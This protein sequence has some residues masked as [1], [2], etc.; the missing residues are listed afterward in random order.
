MVDRSLAEKFERVLNTIKAYPKQFE[1]AWDEVSALELPENY[2]SV[3]NIVF[4]GMG[5]SA[6]GARM[7][8]AFT[9]EGRLRVP[10]EIF[11]EYNIPNYAGP[12]TL[13]ILSSYSGNTEETINA[14]STA[15]AKKSKIFG[16]TTGGKLAEIMR[17]ESV[18]GYIFDPKYNPS[19]Q[20]RMSIGYASGAVLAVISK[21][22]LAHIAHAEIKEAIE[23]MQS[24]I[25]ELDDST[26]ESKN[27]AMNF[28]KKIRGKLPVLVSSEHLTGVTHAVKNQFNESAKTFATA[29]DLPELNHHLMEGLARPSEIKK[30]LHFVFFTSDLYSNRVRERYPLT[31]DVVGQ[32]D[33]GY[34]IYHASSKSKL[35][36]IYEVL[37]FGSFV[38]Y[39]LTK[40]LGIDPMTISWVD[41]FKQKLSETS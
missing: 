34:D 38:V 5:G 13:V 32:N 36:Q 7:I 31:A 11:T 10:F 1:Q 19:L 17:K 6:L 40:N 26:P 25:R 9:S 27:E 14:A 4:C 28:V 18:F 37:V 41:Y 3:E 39:Y 2:K 15:I 20:P 35:G 30:L 23:V 24:A 29:F 22:G 21:L 33:V 12:K 16:L 8:D